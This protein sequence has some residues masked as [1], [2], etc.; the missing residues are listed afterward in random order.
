M[1]VAH[2]TDA[3]S[4]EKQE[5]Q[6][7]QMPTVTYTV[8]AQVKSFRVV[9]F[10][11]DSNYTAPMEGDWYYVSTYHGQLPEGMTLRNCWSWRFNGGIFIAA[12][13]VP[14]TPAKEILL[15]HNRR[16]LLRILHEKINITRAPYAPSCALGDL[17][18]QSKFS[19]ANEW[20]SLPHSRQ[21]YPFLEGVAMARNMPVA[22]A[23]Q[24]IVKRAEQTEQILA[25][26]ERVREKFTVL[27]QQ[28]SSEE[29]LLQI[30]IWLLDDVYPELTRQ[31]RFPV[32][33]TEPPKP[34]APLT[35]THRRHEIARLQVQLRQK[36]NQK[37]APCESQ[38]LQNDSMLQH[39]AMLAKLLLKNEWQSPT[40]VDFTVLENYA[41]ARGLT[42]KDGAELIL[43]FLGVA[44]QLL[45]DTEKIKDQMMARIDALQTLGDIYVLSA[46]IEN[47]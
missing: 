14:D 8:V 18:R 11:D 17:T 10:T 30:R 25:A 37:R 12:H 2:M 40:N 36:I 20:L 38:Y 34:D 42:L 24:L 9:Y 46:E 43:Q 3:V 19:E 45:V 47:I 31:F 16:A 27:I 23:A 39:K 22:D 28:A 32:E 4:Q 21:S 44:G 33:N 1:K 5:D 15:D 13:N 26:T 35:E 6:A 41:Q 7:E 29:A